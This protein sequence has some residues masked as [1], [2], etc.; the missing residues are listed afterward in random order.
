MID[1]DKYVVIKRDDIPSALYE[2]MKEYPDMEIEDAVVIRKQDVFAEAGLR[3]Y[4]SGILTTVEIV[5][6]LP[7]S[8]VIIDLN[9]SIE[10]MIEL[11]DFFNGEADD[12]RG[13]I[14][15]IPD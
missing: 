10:H 14:H 4:A 1:R 12:S 2:R 5:Q 11:A 15:K 13:Y 6:N 7:S 8:S 9:G 3:A